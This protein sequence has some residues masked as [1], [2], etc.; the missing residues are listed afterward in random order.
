[1]RRVAMHGIDEAACR[2]ISLR[3]NGSLVLPLS[4]TAP[5]AQPVSEHAPAVEGSAHN[6][7]A[8][9]F[10]TECC[11]D[12]NDVEQWLRAGKPVLLS[13]DALKRPESLIE[14]QQTAR[15]LNVRLSCVN[16]D[17]WLPSR[18]LIQQQ[19]ASR[20]LGAVGLLRI[21]D[22]RPRHESID[23]ANTIANQSNSRLPGQLLR[24]L[25]LACWLIGR[26]PN[27]VY[28]VTHS[29]PALSAESRATQPPSG[30]LDDSVQGDLIQIHLGF[31]PED[32][33]GEP[34]NQIARPVDGLLEHRTGAMALLTYSSRLPAGDGYQS[35]SVIGASGAAYADDH[36]DRQL[37]FLGGTPRAVWGG[38][39]NHY[40]PLIQAFIDRFPEPAGFQ[41]PAGL[42]NG[43]LEWQRLIDLAT[44][45]QKSLASKQSVILSD[46]G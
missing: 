42:V 26:S 4:T 35:L 40:V 10:L 24:D 43:S 46:C 28:A 41:E 11:T 1:M 18:Q 31:G 22:W 3:L 17:R 2:E 32:L 19:I 33:A 30:T 34:R 5:Q 37:V 12:V 29:D 15:A 23:S 38:E 45:V 9:A 25:D 27:V 21:H 14:L 7:D 36:R 13:C 39:G 16:P 8:V 6:V 44:A 20:K